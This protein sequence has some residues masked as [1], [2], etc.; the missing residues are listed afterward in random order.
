MTLEELETLEKYNK[1]K[2]SLDREMQGKLDSLD[3]FRKNIST[4]NG[5]TIYFTIEDEC[6]KRRTYDKIRNPVYSM[7]R[8]GNII[9]YN[10]YEELG[11]MARVRARKLI[12]L[13]IEKCKEEQ[14]QKLANL[15][16][17]LKNN[18]EKEGN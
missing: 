9:V 5:V 12:D 4:D 18:L 17:E 13:I 16:V 8:T 6:N 3:K 14:E 10:K 11:K 1:D 7:I 2:S 15:E